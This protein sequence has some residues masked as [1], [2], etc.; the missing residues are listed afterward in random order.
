MTSIPLEAK[1]VNYS[2]APYWKVY[3][4]DEATTVEW[5]E[6]GT[7]I[8]YDLIIGVEVL[9][10]LPVDEY[11]LTRSLKLT[12]YH[13][14]DYFWVAPIDFTLHGVGKT[15][16]AAVED[17]GYALVEYY[18]DLHQLEDTLAPHLLEHL[19]FLDDLISQE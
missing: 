12:L 10:D 11:S 9:R 16:E 4:Q 1:P 2:T 5:L 7:S 6:S 18:E 8:T 15:P 13:S 17:F 19:S 3:P 14:R